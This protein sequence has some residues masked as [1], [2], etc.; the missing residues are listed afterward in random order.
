MRNT[1]WILLFLAGLAVLGR[2]VGRMAQRGLFHWSSLRQW[3]EACER[4]PLA[5]E[6]EP[7]VRLTAPTAGLDLLVLN[8]SKKSHLTRAPCLEPLGA[9]TLIL[10]HRDTHFR[11][12]KRIE[13]GDLIQLEQRD[14]TRQTYRISDTLIIDSDDT[15]RVLR[16][17]RTTPR[18]IL[19]T[20][21]PFRYIGSAPSRILFFAD[22]I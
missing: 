22:P 4:S 5:H 1:F 18:L 2:P 17:Y 3:D 16:T 15:E 20:C 9:A 12:L 6:G 19:L 10:A 7:I 13:V 8:G 14:R 21:Y 11:G